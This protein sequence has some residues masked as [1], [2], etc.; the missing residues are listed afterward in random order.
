MLDRKESVLYANV[1]GL[2]LRSLK[3]DP[4]GSGINLL[5]EEVKS[6]AKKSQQETQRSVFLVALFIV[7]AGLLLL[8]MAVYY[9][10]YLPV[11]APMQPLKNR[12]MLVLEESKNE[13]VDVAFISDDTEEEIAV[14]NGPGDE[15]GVVGYVSSGEIYMA[16]GQRAGWVRITMED[17]EGWIDGDQLKGLKTMEVEEFKTKKEESNFKEEEVSDEE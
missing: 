7:I 13:M 14:Y 11:P 15:S 2:G 10:V 17:N 4:I 5:P 12:I 3:S 16:T 6:Q 9:L 8:G 1:I